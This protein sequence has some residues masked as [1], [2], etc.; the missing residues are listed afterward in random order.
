MATLGPSVLTQPPSCGT[1]TLDLDHCFQGAHSIG[2]GLLPRAFFWERVQLPMGEMGGVKG[3]ELW[4][5]L[6][7]QPQPT[8][9]PC[10]HRTQQVPASRQGHSRARLPAQPLCASLL[11]LNASC[12]PQGS[13][14]HSALRTWNKQKAGRGIGFRCHHRTDPCCSGKGSVW[15]QQPMDQQLLWQRY[16]QGGL[17]HGSELRSSQVL[18]AAGD[19]TSLDFKLIE[20]CNSVNK[21][22]LQTLTALIKYS[23]TRFALQHSNYCLWLMIHTL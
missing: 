4:P 20:D 16:N 13:L 19:S 1:L 23:Q 6:G 7:S 3:R 14:T 9:P 2:I 11:L 8:L 12:I 15:I 18:R 21:K 17:I 10:S 5:G 22:C